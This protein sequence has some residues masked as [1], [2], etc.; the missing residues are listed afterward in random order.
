MTAAG[1]WIAILS[2]CACSAEGQ[3]LFRKQ[4]DSGL[5]DASTSPTGGVVRS[6]MSLQYQITGE[7]DASVDAALYVVDLFDTKA[8]QVT[9]LRAAGRVVVAYVSVGTLES[10]RSDA[11]QFPRTAVGRTVPN[12]SNE[13]WLDVRDA[14]VRRLMKARLDRAVLKGFD[15]IFAST[16]G[17]YRQ[18]SGF[19]LTRA[20]ELDYHTFLTSA[21]HAAGLAIGLSGD[22]ELSAELAPQYDFAIATNCIARD[23]CGDLAPLQANG[24]PV[25][26]LESATD[27]DL[28][29]ERAKSFGI[30]VTFKDARYGAARSTCP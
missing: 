23:S 4:S 19:A 22:F 15:G 7:V 1:R 21:A 28:I 12:Y 9:Q 13:S 18:N 30:D 17:A 26:D 8:E 11:A 25:F 20:D 29:C 10:W 3:L 24:V 16:L 14:E 2:L 27:H 5:L 6:D